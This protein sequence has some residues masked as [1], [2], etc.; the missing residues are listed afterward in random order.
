MKKLFAVFLVPLFVYTY[1]TYN[2]YDDSNSPYKTTYPTYENTQ[3]LESIQT[4][5]KQPTY[6]DPCTYGG[7]SCQPS[8]RNIK[9]VRRY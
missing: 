6:S 5:K 7:L 4:S 3:S 8:G 1:G 2:T 9:N